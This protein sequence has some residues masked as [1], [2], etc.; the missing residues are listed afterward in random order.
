MSQPSPQSTI[1]L[2]WAQKL[3]P[4]QLS[5]ACVQQDLGWNWAL[6]RPT[7]KGLDFPDRVEQIGY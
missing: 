6:S 7:L 4:A 1:G 2:G 3:D 5:S